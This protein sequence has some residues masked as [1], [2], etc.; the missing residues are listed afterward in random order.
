M[1][2]KMLLLLVLVSSSIFLIF[3]QNY[4]KN[5]QQDR[6]IGISGPTCLPFLGNLLDIWKDVKNKKSMFSK[7]IDI[8]CCAK[9]FLFYSV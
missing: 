4:F 2:D 3:L 1:L 9:V 8:E 6:K 5:L 7:C